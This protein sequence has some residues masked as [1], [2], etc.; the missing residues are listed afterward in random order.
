MSW[1][2]E[3]RLA[4]PTHRSGIA[5][6]TLLVDEAELTTVS[7]A[8]PRSGT[9]TALDAPVVRPPTTWSVP[10]HASGVQPPPPERRLPRWTSSPW[11]LVGRRSDAEQATARWWWLGV[12]GGAGVSTLERLVPG[13]ADA[14]RLWP[15]PRH[16]GPDAVLLVCRT[17][18][19]GLQQA[20]DAVRQWTA[21]DAP[22]GLRLLG[23]VAVA[24]A[25]GRL[26]A[27]QEEGLRLLSGITPRV[28]RVPWV[29]ALRSA[30]R[31]EHFP[32]PPSL[33][34]M[35][36]DLRGLSVPDQPRRDP[37]Q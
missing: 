31:L 26:K 30:T 35:T 25:P 1:G 27:N 8:P 13:G 23:A 14:Y 15:D 7:G 21:G 9:A 4:A 12:H 10:S 6:P 36:Q 34:E 17:S 32:V 2:R 19:T 37:Q 16:G 5:V 18:I 29:D 11:P 33:I 24:D 20:G 3:R 28:W 22:E